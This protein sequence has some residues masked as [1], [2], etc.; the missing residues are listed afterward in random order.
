MYIWPHNY[1]TYLFA[2]IIIPLTTYLPI[3]LP[4]NYVFICIW[5]FFQIKSPLS[6]NYCSTIN[7]ADESVCEMPTSKVIKWINE[8]DFQHSGNMLQQSNSF[9][10]LATSEMIA[11][12]CKEGKNKGNKW[13]CSEINRLEAEKLDNLSCSQLSTSSSSIPSHYLCEDNHKD[14]TSSSFGGTACNSNSQ[15]ISE[16]FTLSDNS[17]LP[18]E[19]S[20]LIKKKPTDLLLSEKS[21]NMPLFTPRVTNPIFDDSDTLTS[22]PLPQSFIES[23]LLSDILHT[24]L[25]ADNDVLSQSSDNDSVPSHYLYDGDC[26]NRERSLFS[27]NCDDTTHY[28]DVAHSDNQSQYS[29]EVI[30]TQSSGDIDY[31]VLAPCDS[32]NVYN[33]KPINLPLPNTSTSTSL[34]APQVIN[35]IFDENTNLSSADSNLLASS[36]LHSCTDKGTLDFMLNIQPNEDDAFSQGSS[37]SDLASHYFY[38]RNCCNVVSRTSSTSLNEFTHSSSDNIGDSS[39]TTEENVSVKNSNLCV[40]REPDSRKSVCLPKSTDQNF[41]DV[42]P[43]DSGIYTSLQSSNKINSPNAE[44]ST[45]WFKQLDCNEKGLSDLSFNSATPSP[46]PSHYMYEQ[47]LSDE[48]SLCHYFDET[49]DGQIGHNNDIKNSPQTSTNCQGKLFDLCLNETA[50]TNSLNLLSVSN[51]KLCATKC[52]LPTASVQGESY[53]VPMKGFDL[54]T[55]SQFS[56]SDTNSEF[57]AYGDS[58]YGDVNFGYMY[59]KS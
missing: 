2:V 10:S 51:H 43:A 21:T 49:A 17:S 46:T 34:F 45:V 38:E 58:D 57:N 18:L 48:R 23:D 59:V 1:C 14:G 54:D 5:L 13:L 52:N 42:S 9:N 30:L 15:C 53:R 11:Y 20:N 55:I 35:P 6:D 32:H 27:S 41:A 25:H 39:N 4:L 12:I 33:S 7:I 19:T 47:G 31:D 50:A 40:Y 8:T 56:D 28:H 36:S 44:F 22:S 24:L 26:S 3:T 29:S 37:N 16:T